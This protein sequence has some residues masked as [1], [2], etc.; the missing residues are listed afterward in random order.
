MNLLPAPPPHTTMAF[1]EKKKSI[2]QSL[3]LPDD[4]YRDLSPKGSVDEGIRDLIR[5]I[6]AIPGLVT[7]SSCAGR[8]SVFLDGP[9]DRPIAAED[10]SPW[11]ASN[12]GKGGGRWLFISHEASELPDSASVDWREKFGLE[13]GVGREIPAGSSLVHLKF[14]PM[15]HFQPLAMPSPADPDRYCTLL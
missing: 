8:I 7:T 9:Q 14:E 10:G 5:E 11:S 13:D 12:G 2:L 15:V 3:S 1:R 6:N 4:A